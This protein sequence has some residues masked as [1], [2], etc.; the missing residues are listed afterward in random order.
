MSRLPSP[1][2]S[3][4]ENACSRGSKSWSSFYLSNSKRSLLFSSGLPCVSALY[5]LLGKFGLMAGIFFLSSRREILVPLFFSSSILN[6]FSISS[7]V[8]LTP[9]TYLLFSLISM[10]PASWSAWKLIISLIGETDLS[11]D[12]CRVFSSSSCALWKWMSVFCS[13]L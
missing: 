2:G 1:L 6:A 12:P 13:S 7:S 9:S 3:S 4:R 5:S 10:S 8:I 11:G